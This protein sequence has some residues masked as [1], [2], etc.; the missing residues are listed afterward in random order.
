V[1]KELS[2]F[3]IDRVRYRCCDRTVKCCENCIHVILGFDNERR[4]ECLYCECK[5]NKLKNAT[6]GRWYTGDSCT[7]EEA[8]RCDKFLAKTIFKIEV[9]E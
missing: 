4:K 1:N 8:A 3:D 5:L 7:S 2:I 6:G 9:L